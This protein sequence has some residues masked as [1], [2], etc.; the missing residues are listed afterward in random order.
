MSPVWV[1]MVR[2]MAIIV[3]A[4]ETIIIGVLLVILIF[5]VQQLVRV[6]QNEVKPIITSAN[7]TIGTVRGT[8]QFVSE[9]L[10]TPTI[11]IVSLGAAV[12]QMAK[13]VFGWGRPKKRR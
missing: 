13:T 7:E 6:F 12:S 5:Q 9:S 2:D 11:K 4:L 1:Q 10:V 8:T 3:L